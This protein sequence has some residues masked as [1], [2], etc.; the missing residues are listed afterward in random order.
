MADAA[1]PPEQ[2]SLLVKSSSNRSDCIMKVPLDSTI[3][4]LKEIL[5]RDYE[6]NPAPSDQ[7]VCLGH[8]QLRALLYVTELSM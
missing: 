7:T 6:G 2:V 3:A 4:E 8:S 1:G 5:H